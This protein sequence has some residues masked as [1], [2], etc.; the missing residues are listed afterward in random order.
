MESRCELLLENYSKVLMIEAQTML[1]M[2]KRDILPAAVAYS[3]E[4][5]KSALNKKALSDA[6]STEYETELST[7]LSKL[8]ECLYNHILELEVAVLNTKGYT[9]AEE[10]AKYFSDT[11]LTIMCLVRQAADELETLVAAKY[12]PY[13]IYSDILFSV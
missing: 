12:W 10:C 9:D 7:K 13:P 5:A 8:C 4:L 11:V 1:S 2:V 3:S 6:I